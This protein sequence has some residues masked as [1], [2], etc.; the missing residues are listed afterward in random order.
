[1]RRLYL[2][3]YPVTHSISPQMQGA[4]IEALGLDYRYEAMPVPPESLAK[5]VEELRDDSV[6]GFNVT[7]PHKVTILPLLNMLDA[8]ASSVGAV[9][10]VV[11]DNGQLRGYNTDSLAAVRALGEAH[12]DLEGCRVVILGAGGAARAIASGL[13]P[14]ARWIRI[15]ARDTAKAEALASE[16][17]ERHG[18]DVLG[19]GLGDV[20]RSVAAADI[21][22]NAT[23]VGMSPDVDRNPVDAHHLHPSLLVFDLVYNPERTRLL[24]DAAAAGAK[25]LGGLTM[26]VYQ[27]AEAL[28]L[29]SGRRAPEEVMMGAA[30]RALRGGKP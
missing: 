1:L 27:G 4:A 25:T 15:L 30:R 17:G 28:R 13:A 11:N 16:V 10:T 26:L 19:E 24:L 20:H 29:W 7:I 18:V 14:K 3:G 8:S 21:L 22:V 9:N 5:V 2:L 6:A 12:G 23:P